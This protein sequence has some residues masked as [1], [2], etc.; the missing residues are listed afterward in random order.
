MANNKYVCAENSG[1]TLLYANRVAIG[2][3]ETFYLITNSDN[4]I[5]LVA[6]VNYYL[7]CAEDAGT[8][9][10]ITNWSLGTF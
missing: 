5:S 10:L 3:W 7:V 2:P 8:K 4:T 9:G 1:T 6:Y